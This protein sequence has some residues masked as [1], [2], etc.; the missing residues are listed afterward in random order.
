MG[1]DRV[2][3]YKE[4]RYKRLYDRVNGKNRENVLTGGR[5]YGRI[6]Y[7][8]SLP[9]GLCKGAGIELP[10]GATPHEAWEAYEK[11]T[12]ISREEAYKNRDKGSGASKPKVPSKQ[13]HT[14]AIRKLESP[15]YSEGTYDLDNL[16][17]VTYPDGFQVTFC[18]IG[19]DYSDE[20]YEEK[21]EEFKKA[22]SD[23]KSSAGKYEGTPEV[24]FHVES[25]EEAVRLAKKYNQISVYDW[26]TDNLIF[27]GGTGRRK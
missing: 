11:G 24:S 26:K 12:G 17:P 5:F 1:T 23:G 4:R 14:D 27:T 8:D 2:E 9:Y 6:N 10:D 18:Q 20:E 3:R 19:D 22:S 25:R 13:R 7:D 21:V 15:D 16:E